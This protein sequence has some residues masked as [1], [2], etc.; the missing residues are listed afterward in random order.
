MPEKKRDY[1][2]VLG[3]SRDARVEEIKRAFRRLAREY[4]PDANPGDPQAEE[5]FK[6]IN[7][8]YGVL[9]DP[10]KKARYDAYGHAGLGPAD[11]PDPF[12]GFG[13]IFDMFFGGGRSRSARSQGPK[14]GADL[15]L[16][17]EV[18]LEE[19][20]SGVEKNVEVERIERCPICEGSGARPGSE[21]IRCSRC[22]GSGQV[23]TVTD[24]LFGRFVSVRTCPVC[25]GAGV[26][27]TDPCPECA[28]L[29]QVRKV[30]RLTVRVP[31]GA[32]NGLRLR[33]PE[34]G[35]AGTRGGPP[36]DLYVDIHVLPHNVFQ[37]EGPDLHLET[38][39]SFVQAALG[40]QLEVPTL[41]GPAPLKVPEGTQPGAVL[42]LRGKG[43][44]QLRGS[45]RG[46]LHVHLDVRTPVGLTPREKELLRE[47]AALRGETTRGKEKG[48]WGRM[49][50]AWN[51]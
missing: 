24:S 26:K 48:L 30:R 15:R 22:H 49:K 32:D 4:H 51:S 13:E 50:E 3:V 5:K 18:T 9:S 47:F 37:R 21:P 39:I 2:E 44:P 45:G 20:F 33:L 28:G 35:E 27:V 1:Y 17:L 42:R 46:D 41:D 11:I 12:S 10:E 19:A 38:E 31:A 36:G 29:G 6:E 43:M 34:E 8:A 16:D 7:E 14:R 23:E 40:T 25:G